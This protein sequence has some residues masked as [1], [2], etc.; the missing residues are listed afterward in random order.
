MTLPA[1]WKS[2]SVATHPTLK[3]FRILSAELKTK[4]KPQSFFLTI[5]LHQLE[6]FR[7]PAIVNI[8]WLDIQMAIYTNCLLSRI[9]PQT[10]QDN[11]WQR[12]LLS[13]GELQPWTEKRLHIFLH[14]CKKKLF[15]N[16]VLLLKYQNQS[17]LPSVSLYPPSQ[18]FPPA[19]QC[20]WLP[21]P[22]F[23]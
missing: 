20:P 5:F 16:F 7:I 15:S 4:E 14:W 21:P 1:K 11:W 22:S 12:N 6:R 13:R 8:C 9:W 3:H 2:I 17:F 23:S 19:S 18:L 10:A